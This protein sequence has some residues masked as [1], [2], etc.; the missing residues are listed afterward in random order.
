MNAFK[1]LKTYCA[2][3]WG[4][5]KPSEGKVSWPSREDVWGSTWVVVVTVGIFAVYLAGIDVVVGWF[6]A[7][8]LGVEG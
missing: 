2:E 5:V 1:K 3:V 6:V 7:W 4:E 8:A